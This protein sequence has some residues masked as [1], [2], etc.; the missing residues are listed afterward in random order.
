MNRQPVS[1]LAFLILWGLW[2]TALGVSFDCSKAG[3]EVER[4]IC[5][6][7]ALSKLDSD[8]A[9]AYRAALS[10]AGDAERTRAIRA[11]QVGW[12]KSRNAC[13][14]DLCIEVMYRTRLASLA[15]ATAS[16]E[17]HSEFGRFLLTY[18]VGRKVCEAYL[19]RL[20]R[21]EYQ[22]HPPQ[23]DRPESN[24]APGFAGLQREQLTL[25]QLRQMWG[26]VYSFIYSGV[27]S[28]RPQ[29]SGRPLEG[30]AKNWPA[31]RYVKPVD[32]DNDG[33]PDPVIV[34]RSG[35]CAQSGPVQQWHYWESI[36]IVLNSSGDGPD[37]ERTRNFFGHPLGSYRL[38]SGKALNGFRPISKRIG[39]FE[40]E[41]QFYFDA[42]FDV[43]GDFR[44][45][46]RN[47]P[48]LA[49]ED[50][51]IANRLGVFLRQGATTT[52][53]CEYWLE[54]TRP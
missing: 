5:A 31:F 52:Q 18:G 7:P 28:P 24:A 41:G 30:D 26:P 2:S 25:G 27:P 6:A 10:G 53:V 21:T 45:S 29:D 17:R 54:E 36:P 48:S 22:G 43:W 4:R 16:A 8:V 47:D 23:C 15:P 35:A 9:A 42:F 40:Y 32:I 39:I 51:E 49:R 11:A 34:W 12:V 50:P 20:N 1:V 44:G 46:R 14:D 13:S 38:P 33:T 3:T 19:V 37:V